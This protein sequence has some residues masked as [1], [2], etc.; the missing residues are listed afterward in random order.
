MEKTALEYAIEEGNL[1]ACIFLVDKLSATYTNLGKNQTEHALELA[2]HALDEKLFDNQPI[3]F[4]NAHLQI[5]CHFAKFPD[6]TLNNDFIDNIKHPQVKQMAN[7]INR[8]REN[9]LQKPLIGRPTLQRLTSNTISTSSP[10]S[11]EAEDVQ[12]KVT[13]HNLS[14]SSSTGSLKNLLNFDSGLIAN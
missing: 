9:P 7:I 14:H 1:W 13:N 5:I 8:C 3:P 4:E 11:L 6:L 12:T 2:I 10:K